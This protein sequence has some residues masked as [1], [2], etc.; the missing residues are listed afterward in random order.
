MSVYYSSKMNSST[1][2]VDS[3]NPQQSNRVNQLKSQVEEVKN[4]MN[5]N[6]RQII[7]R[8]ERL[9]DVENR[10]NNLSA[11]SQTFQMSARSV[12]RKMWWK[13]IKWTFIMIVVITLV[14]IAIL[15]L[16]LHA[17]NVI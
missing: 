11:S 2:N 3:E 7:E 4:V 15:L 6:I 14:A 8:G 12:Q 17:C 5:D 9:E 1:N 13:N 16:I 10:A